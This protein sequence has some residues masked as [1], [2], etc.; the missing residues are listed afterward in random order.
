MKVKGGGHY[1]RAVNDGARTVFYKIEKMYQV[2][3]FD[4]F[5]FMLLISIHES[6]ETFQF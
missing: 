2:W 5:F 4:T 1:L 3:N 6:D